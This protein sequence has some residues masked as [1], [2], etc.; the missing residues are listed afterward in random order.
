MIQRPG[1]VQRTA[2]VAAP[3]IL[4]LALLFSPSFGSD[5]C[6]EEDEWKGM[7]FSDDLG[8]NVTEARSLHE[9]AP[10]GVWR[11]DCGENGSTKLLVWDKD[12]VFICAA[13]TA[14]TR[15][16]KGH[17][18]DIVRAIRIETDGDR[19]RAVGPAQTEKARWAVS[20]KIYAPRRIDLDVQAQNGG[21]SVE[22]L[23]GRINLKSTNG[24][25]AVIDVGG[26]VRGR[27]SNGPVSAHLTGSRWQG[28][29][30]DL[31]TSNGPVNLSVP[32][33][34]SCELE[35]GTQN[36]PSQ[37]GFA[38]SMQEGDGARIK[39]VLGSGGPPVRVVTTNGPA[40]LAR[41]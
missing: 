2:L 5:L 9:S 16:D 33:G 22:G 23:Y 3:M 30:L 26:D 1:F 41:N 7:Y 34:Y 27:T 13:V 11:I 4:S 12:E 21:V 19:L 6:G 28:A 31:E 20:Y 38:V 24:P 8:K 25:L 37:V 36:G 10:S 14:W 29:G 17:P 39:A 40:T 15:N 18:E 35:T 32:K